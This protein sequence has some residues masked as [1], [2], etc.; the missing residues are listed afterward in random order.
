MSSSLTLD[1]ADAAQRGEGSDSRRGLRV[2][3][4]HDELWRVTLPQGEVLGYIERF[5]VR[6]GARYRAKR[7]LPRQRRFLVDGE[8]WAME[9][10]LDCFASL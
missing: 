6:Q 2:V 4:L 3:Q 1:F 8:F 5:A 10:A 7:F 9:N